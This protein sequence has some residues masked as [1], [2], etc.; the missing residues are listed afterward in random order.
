MARKFGSNCA[1]TQASDHRKHRTGTVT[2]NVKGKFAQ[3]A[4][5]ILLAITLMLAA[6]AGA[7]AFY[8]TAMPGQSFRGAS[9]PLSADER[10][11]ANALRQHVTHLAVE[12]GE[13][14]ATEGDSLLRAERCPIIGPSGKSVTPPSW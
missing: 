4:A 3:K 12:I 2:R 8:C 6:S 10:Q 13:R 11:V 9:P 14:R 5:R 7:T 1:R